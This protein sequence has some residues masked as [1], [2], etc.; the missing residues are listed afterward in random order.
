MDQTKLM[1]YGTAVATAFEK[2]QVLSISYMNMQGD[3]STRRIVPCSPF[4]INPDGTM[5]FQ[6][7]S[8]VIETSGND[9]GHGVITL[10]LDN[11]LSLE[12]D[13]YEIEDVQAFWRRILKA[14][15]GGTVVFPG[16]ETKLYRGHYPA[17]TVADGHLDVYK[18]R[19]WTTAP[20]KGFV[21]KTRGRRNFVNSA[22]RLSAFQ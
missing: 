3:I 1:A 19:G 2:Q 6:A 16:P 8:E 15:N 4:A 22:R 14:D 20:T 13:G 21:Q 9:R 7:Y 18:E 10:R 11:I 5:N 17:P 12:L